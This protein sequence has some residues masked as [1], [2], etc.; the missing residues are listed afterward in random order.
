M[1]RLD[2]FLFVLSKKS[3]SLSSQFSALLINGIP[4][5]PFL[6][7][8]TWNICFLFPLSCHALSVPFRSRKAVCISGL[9]CLRPALVRV[10]L[11]QPYCTRTCL[12]TRDFTFCTI[13]S[14]PFIYNSTPHRW[15]VPF[16]WKYFHCVPFHNTTTSLGL[17]V[18]FCSGSITPSPQAQ[19]SGFF[20]Q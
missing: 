13:P 14:C 16:S 11:P 8:E 7:L 5:H 20:Y 18:P 1:C 6:L 2:V 19:S 9:H 15:S 3:L 4:P 17:L 12:L 10:S